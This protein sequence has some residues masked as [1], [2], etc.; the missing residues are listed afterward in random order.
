LINLLTKKR[1]LKLDF[2]NPLIRKTSLTVIFY[3]CSWLIIYG[4]SEAYPSGP[5]V[6]GLGVLAFVLL[7]VIA[8]I[9]LG[10]NFYQTM[11]GKKENKLSMFIHLVFVILFVLYFKLGA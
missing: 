1:K 8:F 2:K 9:L 7:P 5:C 11:E 10:Y 6:P 4:L 3:L